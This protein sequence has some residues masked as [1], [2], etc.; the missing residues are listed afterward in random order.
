MKKITDKTPAEILNEELKKA[1]KEMVLAAE[2][3]NRDREL[4]EKKITQL[5]KESGYFC[6]VVLDH[7]NLLNISNW[8]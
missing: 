8:H 4:T 1:E 5:A 3:L 2:K 6:G 7:K